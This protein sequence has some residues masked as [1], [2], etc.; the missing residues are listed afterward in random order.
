MVCCELNYIISW[1]KVREVN[2]INKTYLKLDDQLLER[3]KE[4]Y[5]NLYRFD[6]INDCQSSTF[7]SSHMLYCLF[8]Y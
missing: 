7:L 3:E 4:T 1:N 5:D 6:L 2:K 8:Q